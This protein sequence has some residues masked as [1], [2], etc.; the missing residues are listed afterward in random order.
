[1]KIYKYWV[2]EK[3]R[4]MIEGEEQEITCYGGSNIYT[5]DAHLQARD[6][7]NFATLDR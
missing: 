2:A 6:Q 5:D 7:R 1:M 3:Q 4:I